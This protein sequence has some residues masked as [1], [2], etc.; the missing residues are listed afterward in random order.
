M[1][2]KRCASKNSYKASVCGTKSGIRVKNFVYGKTNF[3]ACNRF[4][5]VKR[6]F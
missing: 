2:Y 5:G 1:I 4:T 3:I 6:H